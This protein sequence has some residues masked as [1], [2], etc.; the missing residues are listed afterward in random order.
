MT[1]RKSP[2]IVVAV[3]VLAVL[4]GVG[5]L[6]NKGGGS[7]HPKA[8]ATSTAAAAAGSSAPK[9][10]P[11]A[12]R[13]PAPSGTWVPADPALADVC[14]TKLPSQAQ[15]TLALI[16]KNGPYPYNRDG[17]VFENRESRLPKK[18]DGYYH[19]FT[20]VTP[21]SNDRGTRRVVTGGAGEQYWS[22]DHYGTFQEIDPRC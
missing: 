9:P 13:S 4:A 11:P 2:L 15:D 21:G 18:G 10:S 3:L 19:E 20:V 6:L 16:A 12:G 5:Y 7:S 17:I 1:R 8:A 22:P 14:R